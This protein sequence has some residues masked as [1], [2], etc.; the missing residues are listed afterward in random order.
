MIKS[1]KS[2]RLTLL[3]AKIRSSINQ[4]FLHTVYVCVRTYVRM[5]VMYVHMYI[6]TYV[7]YFII[8][9]LIVLSNAI[10]FFIIASYVEGDN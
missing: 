4:N 5:Y 2:T 3:L 10:Y 8:S 1:L 9:D 7:L 6:C